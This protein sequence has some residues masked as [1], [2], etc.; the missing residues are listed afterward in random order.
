M[1]KPPQVAQRRRIKLHSSVAGSPRIYS[2]FLVLAL[3]GVISSWRIAQQNAIL[4]TELAHPSMPLGEI[5]QLTRRIRVLEEKVDHHPDF[6]F[7]NNSSVE[8]LD[9]R[10][11]VDGLKAEL[12]RL[13]RLLEK[14]RSE[15]I[16]F[17]K[18]VMKLQAMSVS[19]NAATN[20]SKFAYAY[21]VGGCDPD[22]PAY[23]YYIYDILISTYI[24]RQDGSSA[25]VVVFFQL[26]FDSKF[27]ELP[28][29]DI[30]LL[31]ALD[32]Q[33]QYIPKRKEQSFYRINLEKFRILDMTEYHRVL[34]MDS[35]ILARNSLDYLFKLSMEG[36]IKENLVFRGSREPANGGLFMLAPKPGGYKR[37]QEI[38]H[39]TEER[40][41]RLDQWNWDEKRGWGHFIEDNDAWVL[42]SGM[43]G[44]HWAFHGGFVD[45]GLLYH[46]VRYE[47]ESVS[48]VTRDSI[49]HWALASSGRQRLE[50]TV[51]L[52]ILDE[53]SK[54][55]PCWKRTNTFRKC[56]SPHSD[57]VHY[58]GRE[59]PWL[60]GP[61]EDISEATAH[62][63]HNNFWFY[64][65]SIL[66]DKLN[67]GLDFQNWKAERPLLGLVPN[68]P[69]LVKN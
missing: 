14:E 28:E 62:E 30:R 11:T 17:K 60:K 42:L 53:Y 5:N 27:E 4:L 58:V 43:N 20:S 41:K 63:H 34:F 19:S 57:F 6:P 54:H 36:V 68:Y 13:N 15:K 18:K 23:R 8:D 10:D 46:W 33:Y 55:N 51:S 26:M 32:I 38:I 47:Q 52:H 22:K 64:M 59:K 21:V 40:R 44:T 25:D 24:Q 65:L 1:G 48:I 56:M 2:L 61:P 67:M 31:R 66:N 39:Q 29:E 69:K 3:G 7:D 16:L 12:S 35:D 50:S 37:I 45:Q 9:Q 49:E